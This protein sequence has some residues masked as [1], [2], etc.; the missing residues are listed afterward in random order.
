[1][2]TISLLCRG[3]S[4]GHV[5]KLPKVN[6]SVIVG[7]FHHEIKN[8][9]VHEYLSRC[10]TLTHVLSLGAYWPNAGADTIY[11]KYNF[12]KIVVPYVK[13]VSPPIP[14][15]LTDILPVYNL[16]DVNKKDMITTPRYKY[17]SP[18]SGLDALLYVVNELKPDEVNI[19]G[20]D[21]YDN[22]G[23]LTNTHG[24]RDGGAPTDVAIKRGEPTDV[25]QNFFKK[26]V[27]SKPSVIFNIY[28][29][30]NIECDVDNLNKIEV[31]I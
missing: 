27:I 23:Y 1:M 19:I 14:K 24:D 31:T 16:S 6:H 2:K 15:R 9:N 17:T 3:V 20:M 28:T 22:T 25:M 21:F 18:T 12:D 10:S 4:L 26:F 7:S 8:K 5:G 13:E 29:S 30:S 11:P